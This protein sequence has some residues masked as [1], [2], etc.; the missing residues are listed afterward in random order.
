MQ[1][2]SLPEFFLERLVSIF[3]P[4]MHVLNVPNCLLSIFFY[5]DSIY[6]FCPSHSSFPTSN[7]PTFD[8]S[9][10]IPP[11]IT[12]TPVDTAY[13]DEIY[14]YDITA[15]DTDNGPEPLAISIQ[16]NPEW[17]NFTDNG[18]GSATLTGTPT[19]AE[20]G[21]HDIVI[22]VSDGSHIV[23]QSYILHVVKPSGIDSFGYGLIQIYPNPA[24]NNL[25]VAN[26]QETEYQI[27]DITGRI[28]KTGKINL[29]LEKIDISD[30]ANG[31]LMIKIFN[32]K[33][34]IIKKIV[35]F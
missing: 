34:V 24:N 7:P 11:R 10:N 3:I 26:C 6:S 25:F 27:Y 29:E 12:S 1:Q 8:P 28:L 21:D 20:L 31:S 4:S 2:K 18:N 22:E 16:G 5:Y 35:K 23:S 17:L 30:F 13:I 14:I 33:E 15:E 9:N 19:E 32:E